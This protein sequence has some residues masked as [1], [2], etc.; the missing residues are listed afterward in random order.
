QLFGAPYSMRI[1]LDPEKLNEFSLTPA[2]VVRAIEVQNNQDAG[3]ELGGA[4]SVRGHQLNATNL[5]QTRLETPEEFGNI[6]LRVRP[7]GSQVRLH[8]VARVELGAQNYAV[9]GRF[10]GRPAAGLAINLA[11]GAN[12]LETAAGVRARMA[13][14]AEFFP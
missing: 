12:A 5:A 14:L 9:E 13:E 10:N 6:L 1:W 7:D 4:P 8:D 11:T 2:D 3:G